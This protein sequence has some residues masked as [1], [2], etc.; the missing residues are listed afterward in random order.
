MSCPYDS[1][2]IL[3][4]DDLNSMT[5]ADRPMTAENR[6]KSVSSKDK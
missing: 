3:N 5:F 2:F 6:A 1:N 4:W